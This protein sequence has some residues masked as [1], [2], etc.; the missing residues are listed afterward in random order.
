VEY[1]PAQVSPLTSKWPAA[2]G[3][4][5]FEPASPTPIPAPPSAC[6][7]PGSEPPPGEWPPVPPAPAPMKPPTLLAAPDPS[8]TGAGTAETR[9]SG[10]AS[11]A[12][13]GMASPAMG[14]DDDAPTMTLPT[15]R[16]PPDSADGRLASVA[17][18][19]PP[20]P[21]RARH[22]GRH[23]TA[24]QVAA[25]DSPIVQLRRAIRRQQ[26]L[27]ARG[28]REDLVWQ[29]KFAYGSAAIIL[30]VLT[31]IS[32]P[33]WIVLYRITGADRA[34]LP[35]ADV[36]ALC[37]MLTGGFL[38]GAA[39]WV[40]IIEMRGRIRMV[41]ELAKTGEREATAPPAPP[42]APVAP[43]PQGPHLAPEMP[44][45]DP[46]LDN[47]AAS[48]RT[49]AGDRDWETGPIQA[50]I[51][52]RVE[53]QQT[54]AAA[55]LEASSKLLSSFSGVLRSYGQLAAQVA[56]LAVALALFVG[57]TALSLH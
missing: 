4:S 6:A 44:T 27:T 13:I 57:A 14:A 9:T 40:I 46:A 20:R 15:L 19:A 26:A 17:D 56:M 33:L 42:V 48:E 41:D 1:Q 32:L 37:M 11:G 30:V 16:P 49:P 39:M 50:R 10:T 25:E 55:T 18:S 52:A 28:P 34:A 5:A 21:P 12:T 47:L 29:P 8:V 2:V 36:V 35:V 38:T 7:A 53:A 54:S 22:T 31:V 23:S 43:A 45:L 3:P 24:A 51:A